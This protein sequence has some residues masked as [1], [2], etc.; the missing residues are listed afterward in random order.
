MQQYL[1]NKKGLV[2]G[3]FDKVYDKYDI[4]ND[5]MS[6]GVHRIWKR[7]LINWMN[8]GKN[9]ILADVAC[10]TGD[11]AKLYID[12]SSNKN[13]ELFCID[14]NEGMMKKGKNRLSNY[15]NIK[16]IKGSAEKLP[17]KSNSCDYYTISFGLRNTKNINKSLSE[18]YRVLKSGGRFFCLEFSKIQNFREK[19]FNIHADVEDLIFDLKS[20]LNEIENYESNLP[21][22]QKRLF[23]L[24]NLERTFSL[25]LTQL[26]EK[27]DQLKTYFQHN[28]QG[29]L[30]NNPLLIKRL[31]KI[32][33]GN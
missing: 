29:N 22:I 9:K 27:R 5:L 15:K 16:W 2:Q 17:L 33:I 24:K 14:P 32:F 6:L 31:S 10:G 30:F 4:M 13:I 25:D 8:P 21:E 1:Q 11:I 26:I 28:D 23:F 7:N 3:V 20:Y 18:A 12:N 19:L